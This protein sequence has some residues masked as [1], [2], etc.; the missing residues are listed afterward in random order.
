VTSRTAAGLFG[1][2]WVVLACAGRSKSTA[3]DEGS[4]GGDDAF[5]GSVAGSMAMGVGGPSTGGSATGGSS[6][7]GDSGTMGVGGTLGGAGA[8]SGGA[9]SPTGG[10]AGGGLG[11]TAGGGIGGAGFANVGCFERGSSVA[12]PNGNVAIETLAVGDEVLA[13][14]A[15]TGSV[16]P[17]AVTATFVHTVSQTGRLALSDGR[18]LRVTAEHPIYLAA[19]G[20]YARADEIDGKEPLVSLT[21]SL[22]REVSGAIPLGVENTTGGFAAIDRPTVVYNIS[23]ADLE[24]YFVEGVLVHN[25]SGAG[26]VP[27]LCGNLIWNDPTCTAHPT[28][29]DYQ[30]VVDTTITT[31]Q[32]AAE[33]G[34]GSRYLDIPICQPATGDEPVFFAVDYWLLNDGVLGS[35]GI[36]DGNE[37]CSGVLSARMN[38]YVE[39]GTTTTTGWTTQCLALSPN[40][41][42]GSRLQLVTDG[43]T[44]LKN[45]RFVRACECRRTLSCSTSAASVCQ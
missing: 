10:V 11:G 27:E 32:R 7:G 43:F 21:S 28:C 24:N 4:H 44:L 13:F 34:T 22:A 39:V 42:G 37:P 2:F 26:N 35:F 17:R 14:D 8:S 6:A 12:T 38:L 16:V 29:L 20:R 40:Q 23:V 3:D 25:K 5:G 41:I 19:E 30:N 36:Y 45:P 33:D 9:G 31:N 18:L 15:R 1:I